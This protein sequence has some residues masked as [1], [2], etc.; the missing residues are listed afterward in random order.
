MGQSSSKFIQYYFLCKDNHR[1]QNGGDRKRIVSVLDMIGAKCPCCG[2]FTYIHTTEKNQYWCT[3]CKLIFD[4][5][6]YSIN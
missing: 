4:E 1:K 2:Q 6:D 5:I 3:T